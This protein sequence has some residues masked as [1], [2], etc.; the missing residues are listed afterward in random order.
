MAERNSVCVRG[1]SRRKECDS[2]RLVQMVRKFFILTTLQN[3]AE[4]EMVTNQAAK[5]FLAGCPQLNWNFHLGDGQEG[6][7]SLQN[8]PRDAKV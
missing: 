4:R 8:V 2:P 3:L 5:C 7:S 1:D 6:N